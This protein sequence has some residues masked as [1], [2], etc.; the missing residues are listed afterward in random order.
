MTP[1]NSKFVN[2]IYATSGE[3]LDPLLEVGLAQDTIH[4]WDPTLYATATFGKPYLLTLEIA[5]LGQRG[6][7]EGLTMNLGYFLFYY[8]FAHIT[9]L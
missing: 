8:A 4:S 6:N 2:H 9:F 7:W 5:L 1:E 3:P